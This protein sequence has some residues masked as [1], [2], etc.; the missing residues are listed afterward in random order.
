MDYSFKQ[1]LPYLSILTS[2][3][4]LYIYLF[5]TVLGWLSFFAVV[6]ILLGSMYIFKKFAVPYKEFTISAAF[7]RHWYFMIILPIYYGWDM[8]NKNGHVG[9][10][11][12]LAIIIMIILTFI[13][14][15]RSLYDEAY[16]S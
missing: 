14:L 6:P 5:P 12:L 9:I 16:S 1:Q 11:Y 13:I 8:Y 7:K 10:W 3:S 15:E 4:W 2:M